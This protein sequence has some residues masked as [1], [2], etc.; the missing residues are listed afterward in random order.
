M[1]FLE[2]LEVCDYCKLVSTWEYMSNV[3][4]NVHVNL[5][6]PIS[7]LFQDNLKL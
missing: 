2:F 7:T 6:S 3:M 5:C 4:F 1:S